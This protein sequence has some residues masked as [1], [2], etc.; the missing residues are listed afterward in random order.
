MDLLK[1]GQNVTNVYQNKSDFDMNFQDTF[2]SYNADKYS[3]KTFS[4]IVNQENTK[5]QITTN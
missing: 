5:K 3:V 2:E 1:R 4:D